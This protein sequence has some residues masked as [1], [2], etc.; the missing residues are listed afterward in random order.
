M[1]PPVVDRMSLDLRARSLGDHATLYSECKQR[2]QLKRHIKFGDISNEIFNGEHSRVDIPQFNGDIDTTVMQM[3]D[4]LYDCA[5]VCMS[6]PVTP[7][8]ERLLSDMDDRRMWQAVDWQGKYKDGDYVN[9]YTKG[10]TDEQFRE[11]YEGVYNP[12]GVECV[13]PNEFRTNVTIPILDDDITIDEV[14]KQV[15]SLKHNKACG[16]DGI[17]HWS[18]R[19]GQLFWK[20]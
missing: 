11:F 9:D 10:A 18:R 13:E 20:V 4:I 19:S 15:H 5:L 8:P 7:T 3:T 16:P 2:S 17:T 1:S 12:H 6:A 14:G